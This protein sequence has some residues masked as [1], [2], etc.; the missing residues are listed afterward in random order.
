MN[1]LKIAVQD[2]LAIVA[3]DRGKSNAINIEMMQEL[4]QIIANIESDDQIG[5]LLLTGK[6]GFFSAG[7]DLIA[8]YNHNEE[9]VKLFW[10]NF[11]G[12]SMKLMSFKKPMVVALN[13]HS[14]AGGCVLALCA[15]Y[16]VMA[17]GE[18]IIGLN[19]IPV[20]IIAPD[21]IFHA[22]EFWL[23]KRTAYQMLLEGK[24][25][26][27][28]EALKIGL[29]DEVVDANIILNTAERKIRTYMSFEPNT[30]QQSKLNLR[31]DL[32]ARMHQ[33]KNE[34]LEVMLKQWWAPTTRKTLKTIIE[35]LGK[36][37]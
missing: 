19:E 34:N 10:D 33:N 25:V 26:S 27:P 4:H 11:I 15:D 7:L 8:L 37:G 30:W 23:G 35:G 22:Y 24:L 12:L 28:N 20:G 21:F 32:L 9:E 3:L 5:G 16:R 18:F 17:K 13:G 29:I 36:N 2:H 1:T 31:R 14:P 6:E